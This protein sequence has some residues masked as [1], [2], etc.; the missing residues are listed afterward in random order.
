LVEKGGRGKRTTKTKCPTAKRGT[1][2]EK[3]ESER[4]GEEDFDREG[5]N[6]RIVHGRIL[7][8]KHLGEAQEVPGGLPLERQGGA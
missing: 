2:C 8:L 4:R 3:R 1:R 7:G 6:S 5:D